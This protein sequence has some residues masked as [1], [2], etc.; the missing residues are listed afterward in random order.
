MARGINKVILIGNLGRDPEIRY[1]PSGSAVTNVTIATT[2]TW[3]DKQ[4][5]EVS[6]VHAPDHEYR[7]RAA[8][9]NLKLRGMLAENQ[10]QDQPQTLA[11]LIM[12]IQ[13]GRVQRGLDIQQ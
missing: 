10:K 6:A 13:Q 12:A 2:D 4:T 8:E 9:M 11:A 7:L 1:M 3:K 5:G